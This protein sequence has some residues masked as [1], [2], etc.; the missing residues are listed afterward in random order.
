MKAAAAYSGL[1]E[2]TLWRLISAGTLPAVRVP[3]MRRVLILRDDLDALLEGARVVRV[4][5]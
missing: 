4:E 5:A 2:R 1:P 3:G